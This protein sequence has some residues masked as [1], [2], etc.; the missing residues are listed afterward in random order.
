MG[1]LRRARD[2]GVARTHL[3]RAAAHRRDQPLFW[4]TLGGL[5]RRA[6]VPPP[7]APRRG[8]DAHARLHG[9]PRLAFVEPDDGLHTLR[10]L[11]RSAVGGPARRRRRE[12]LQRRR[13]RRR[14]LTLAVRRFTLEE[15]A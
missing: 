14:A 1:R 8:E 12:P 2:S 6:R 4:K 5:R 9:R 7:R 11:P 13:A 10:T 15:G 3:L